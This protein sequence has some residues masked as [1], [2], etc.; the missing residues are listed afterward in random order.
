MVFS[1]LKVL[2]SFFHRNHRAV[3]QNKKPLKLKSQING[4]TLAVSQAED[5]DTS[6]LFKDGHPLNCHVTLTGMIIFK[7]RRLFKFTG[8]HLSV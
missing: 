3:G 7:Q 6:V 5:P 8:N 1:P 2:E 4:L